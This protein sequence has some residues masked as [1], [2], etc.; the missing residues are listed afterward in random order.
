MA[1]DIP[2]E[3]LFEEAARVRSRAHAPYS[4]FPVGAAVLYSD[5]AVV[6]GCN[7]ENATYGL[8]VCAER[9]ALAAG[10]AQGH[11]RPVA[12]AIVVDT[13][14]PCPPCGMCRQVM[15]EFASADLPVR[16]RTPKGGEARYTLGELLPHAF[17][18]A[19]F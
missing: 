19:F 2:W 5:G 1:D 15:A 3:R 7:V 12:V 18:K 8:T 11:G 14:E 17:T 16:S 10:V 9:N 6:P 4:R 13:P